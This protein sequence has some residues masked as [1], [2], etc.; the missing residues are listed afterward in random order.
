MIPVIE[1]LKWRG[2]LSFTVSAPNEI[3][4]LI[5]SELSYIP[6]DDLVPEFEFDEPVSLKTVGEEFFKL[7][8][9]DFSLG[10]IIPKEILSLFKVAISS[11][12]Y[13][14]VMVWGYVNEL[15]LDSEKQFSAVA[16]SLETGVTYV[17]YRG[18]DDTL[19]GWKEDLNMA[20]FMP[21]PAQI[22]GAEYLESVARLSRDKLV[23]IGHSKGGNIAVYSALKTNPKIKKRIESVYS[24]DGPGFSEDFVKSCKNDIIVPKIK[25]VLPSRAIIGRIFDIIGEYKIVK[26][27][28]KGLQQHNA[29][30]WSLN[31]PE[32]A[33]AECFEKQ[34]DNFH[35]LLKTWVS[36]M[37][38][39]EKE[40]FVSSFYKIITSNDANTLTDISAQKLKFILAM[41][42]SEGKS[43]RTV[44]SGVFK[45]IKE[46]NALSSSQKKEIKKQ[47]SIAKSNKN[48]EKTS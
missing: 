39:K 3:D 38:Q 48:K 41:L 14:R 9:E 20:L 2:D 42:K 24:F 17:T 1:Y 4:A 8:G 32:F 29:L 40:D 23:V 6:F 44:I 7:H 26:S 19:V 10:A 35:I 45:L 43:K 27:T 30:T 22:R 11:E 5:F 34:S 13:S 21:I 25:T 36:K 28:E 16:F 18:T 47:K 33:E 46:K 31:G 15:C 37:T 12:R